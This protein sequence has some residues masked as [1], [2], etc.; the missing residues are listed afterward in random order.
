MT[1]FLRRPPD[2]AIAAILARI[3]YRL[4][5]RPNRA[6]RLCLR[7]AAAPAESGEERRRFGRGSLHAMRRVVG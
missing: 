6:V 5:D 2:E 1:F 4:G 7:H 3:R